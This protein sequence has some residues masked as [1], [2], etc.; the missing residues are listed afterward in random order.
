MMSSHYIEHLHRLLDVA[1]DLAV[2]VWAQVVRVD[3][4]RLQA[5]IDLCNVFLQI[6]TEFFHPGSIRLNYVKFQN[7]SKLTSLRIKVGA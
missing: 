4:S 1:D 6:T 7:K 3:Y 5:K 2:C